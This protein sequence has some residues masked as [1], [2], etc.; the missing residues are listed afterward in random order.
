MRFFI[1]EIRTGS[2][3]LTKSQNLSDQT[4]QVE[5]VHALVSEPITYLTRSEQNLTNAHFEDKVEVNDVFWSFIGNLYLV[6]KRQLKSISLVVE[7]SS[8]RILIMN[9]IN[10]THMPLII[11]ISRNSWLCL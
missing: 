7:F 11:C 4:R 2:D 1:I 10:Q 3:N 8:V 5:E 6:G 9:S